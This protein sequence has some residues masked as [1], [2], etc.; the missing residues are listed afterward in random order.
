MSGAQ[1]PL[2]MEPVATHI[3]A[4]LE[5]WHVDSHTENTD[6]QGFLSWYGSLPWMKRW[7]GKEIK[8]SH[9]G[10][11]ADWAECSSAESAPHGNVRCTPARVAAQSAAKNKIACHLLSYLLDLNRQVF[12]LQSLSGYV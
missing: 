4:I 1:M 12:L 11:E 9:A 7:I 8:S 2:H 6:H 10:E 5:S 3:F